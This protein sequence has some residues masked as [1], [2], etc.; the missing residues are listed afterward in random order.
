MPKNPKNLNRLEVGNP[1]FGGIEVIQA[2]KRPTRNVVQAKMGYAAVDGVIKFYKLDANRGGWTEVGSI[3]GNGATYSWDAIRYGQDHGGFS[4]INN[5]WTLVDD[6]DCN[7]GGY[8]RNDGTNSC[9]AGIGSFYVSTEGDY[10]IDI[11]CYTEND[12]GKLDITIDGS[13]ACTIDLYS[14]S[15]D[16]NVEFSESIGTLAVGLHTIKFIGNGRNAS[17]SAYYLR[18]QAFAIYL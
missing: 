11:L 7:I 6:I 15:T 5:D 12:A 2:H 18:I 3:G 8:L 13:V 9:R 10:T 14:A 4:N 16:K 17:S 1:Q